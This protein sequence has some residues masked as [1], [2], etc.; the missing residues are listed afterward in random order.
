MSTST[1]WHE[2]LEQVRRHDGDGRWRDFRTALS[3]FGA[4]GPS[5]QALDSAAEE[6]A[7]S[8]RIPGVE[9]SPEM[10]TWLSVVS[11]RPHCAERQPPWK[12]VEL[13]VSAWSVCHRQRS[14]E[15]Q[16]LLRDWASAYRACGGDPRPDVP[17]CTPSGRDETDLRRSAN[18]SGRRLRKGFA[19]TG[20]TLLTAL[21]VSVVMW[22]A[23]VRHDNSPGEQRAADP[24][25]HSTPP[26]TASASTDSKPAHPSPITPKTATAAAPTPSAPSS[27]SPHRPTATPPPDR[28]PATSEPV[29][30]TVANRVT[31]GATQMREDT[32]H[33]AY[34]ST[35]AEK[36]CKAH[37]PACNVPG[38]LAS[39]DHL[40]A[41]CRTTGERVTNG[42]DENTV[43]D[44]NPGLD[45]S[46]VWYRLRAADG[47]SGYLSVV[48]LIPDHRDGLGLPDC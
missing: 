10:S 31:D 20:V 38:D 26:K 41:M 30:V 27:S 12:Y 2:L 33:P 25:R 37:R 5:F 29:T 45:E 6:I 22:F 23:V 35:I 40:T 39:G 11:T 42:Q 16:D 8:G 18:S 34:L 21:A 44:A 15:T 36:K 43:D 46:T 24:G 13:L 7:G 28:S 14:H 32:D 9:A 4:A 3:A 17:A 47:R 1:P 48:W 19:A